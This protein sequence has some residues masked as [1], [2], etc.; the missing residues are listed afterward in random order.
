MPLQIVHED[1][2]RYMRGLLDRH[3][4]PVLVEMEELA[5]EKSFPIVNRHVGVTIELLTRLMRARRIFELG[6]GYGYSAYW[7][8]RG[9]GP[10]GEVHC[11]DGDPANERAAAD[12]LAR[13]GLWE[14]I[15]FHVGDAVTALRG[16]PGEFDVIYCDIDKHGYPEAWTAARERIRAGGLY[17]CDNVLWSGRVTESPPQDDVP[18]WTEAVLEHNRLIATDER[19]L[20]SILPIRDGVMVALRLS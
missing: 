11:T 2:E 7:F 14:R 1:V 13:A 9:A 5:R 6:S 20:S 10:D 3:D 12:F 16:V 19:Y 18:G 8:A 15:D 4:E 17:V